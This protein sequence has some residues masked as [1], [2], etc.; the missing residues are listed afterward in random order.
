[1]DNKS[2]PELAQKHGTPLYV[3]DEKRLKDRVA[4]LRASLPA[5]TGIC[6]AM[7]A[8]PFVLPA[9]SHLVDRI[10]VCSEGEQRICAD[11]SIDPEKIVISGVSK[12]EEAILESIRAQGATGRYTVESVGQFNMLYRIARNCNARLKILM[13]L[14]SGNQFGMDGQT[15]K[16]LASLYGSDP[17]LDI[18]GIQFFSGTQKSSL[19]RIEKEIGLL[20]DLVFE[21][22][23]ENNLYIR[24]VEYGPG[25]PVNYFD[26]RPRHEIE[27]EE[28]AFFEQVSTLMA[29]M[30][31]RRRMILELGRALVASCGTYVTRVMDTKTNGG[32]NYA[33][34]D[35]GIHHLTYYGNS[36]ALKKPPC[37]L[38]HDGGGPPDDTARPWTVCG[39]LCTVNDLLTKRTEFQGLGQGSLLAFEQAGAYCM[40]EGISLFLSR[41]LPAIVVVDG[42]GRSR[43][44][45][46]RLPTSPVNTPQTPIS[47][48][49]TSKDG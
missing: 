19:D 26:D 48:T 20:G 24:E 37:R 40:T 41:D 7:K 18:C 39:S 5:K 30:R 13:R 15:V 1:M 35:G 49:S 2:L 33:I 43:T 27:A 42:L 8:N 23:H 17:Y 36:L 47:W 16:E 34:V 29:K 22:Q 45:R 44:V 28:K 9:I 31:T 21:L 32:E 11:L 12:D 6:Y 25:F 46:A 14:T 38:V 3:F 4:S 10:E